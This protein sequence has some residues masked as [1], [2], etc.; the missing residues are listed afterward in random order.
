MEFIG[1]LDLQTTPPAYHR[2]VGGRSHGRGRSPINYRAGAQYSRVRVVIRL[3]L[4]RNVI[5]I[6]IGVF[7]L[8]LEVP[9]A[10]L[11]QT[12]VTSFVPGEDFH[13]RG[14]RAMGHRTLSTM[15]Q[16]GTGKCF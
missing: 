7:G 14:Y 10:L 8:S 15:A 12:A 3:S 1:E 2:R 5:E 4:R 9:A 16:T 6:D 11:P 13:R